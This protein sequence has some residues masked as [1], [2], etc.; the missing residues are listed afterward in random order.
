VDWGERLF[1]RESVSSSIGRPSSSPIERER[2]REIESAV[3]GNTKSLYDTS[4][5]KSGRAS[6]DSGERLFFH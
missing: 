1:I 5:K 6:L 4:Q 3:C 2:E